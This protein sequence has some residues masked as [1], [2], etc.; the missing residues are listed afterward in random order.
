VSL[1]SLALAPFWAKWSNLIVTRG[2]FPRSLHIAA[3]ILL[4]VAALATFHIGPWVL[5]AAILGE[6]RLPALLYQEGIGLAAVILFGPGIAL[7]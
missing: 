1:F 3:V 2:E 4:S 7:Q 5:W 6:G